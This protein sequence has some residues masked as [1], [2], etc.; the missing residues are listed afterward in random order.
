MLCGYQD[1]SW[2]LM[3]D[4]GTIDGDGLQIHMILGEDSLIDVVKND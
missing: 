1:I 4:L 3:K 2:G